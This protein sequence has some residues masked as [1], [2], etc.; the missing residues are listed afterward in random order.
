[1]NFDKPT[2]LENKDTK[3]SFVWQKVENYA[4]T[5]FMATLLSLAVKEGVAQTE[6]KIDSLDILKKEASI[7]EKKI[8]DRVVK[9]GKDGYCVL[10]QDTTKTKNLVIGGQ[11]VEVGYDKK[12]NTKWLLLQNQD[13]SITLFDDNIDGQIDRMI[14]NNSNMLPELKKVDGTSNSLVDIND[15]A[16]FAQ[17]ASG[18]TDKSEIYSISKDRSSIKSVSYKTGETVEIKGEDVKNPIYY[19]QAMFTHTLQSIE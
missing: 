9:N 7:A 1:M 12:G 18:L 5:V 8:V 19:M 15:L 14:H 2:N 6:S 10:N 4:K 16:S 13:G 11:S 17:G 3:K